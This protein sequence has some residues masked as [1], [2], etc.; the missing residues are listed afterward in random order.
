MHTTKQI[1]VQRYP[2][3]STC[4]ALMAERCYILLNTGIDSIETVI[5]FKFEIIIAH[6]IWFLNLIN[7]FNFDFKQILSF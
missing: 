2:D 6:S 1:E 7:L 3:E 4:F 5:K